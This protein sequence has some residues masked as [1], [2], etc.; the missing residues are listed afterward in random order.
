MVNME[1]LPT[2]VVPA[3]VVALAI[4][5]I[6]CGACAHSNPGPGRG[7]AAADGAKRIRVYVG[8]YT[9]TTSKGIYCL[10]L[11]PATG[12]L[13]PPEVAAETANPSFLAT[14]TGK[15]T[16]TLA[17]TAGNG[18]S[19]LS[20]FLYAVGEIADFEG[21]KSGSVSAFAMDRTSGKLTLLNQQPSGGVGPCHLIVDHAGKNL[22]VAN[23]SSG[24]VAVC[25]IG[26]DGRLA[27]PSDIAQHTGV[28]HRP[29]YQKSPHAHSVN[30]DAAGRFA[31]VADLG[32]DKVFVYRF[33]A[34]RG[35]LVPNDPAAVAVAPGTG[36][37]H[38]AF[39]PTGR[40]AYVI[41]ELGS[42]VT[43]FA[44]DSAR[45]VLTEVQTVST[46]PAGVPAVAEE[47]STA[48]VAVHPSGRFLY[49]SNRGH[50]S[51]AVFAIDEKTGKLTPISHQSTLGKTPRNF[52]IDPAG[53]WLLA[54][55]QDSD[56]IV[57]FRID[58]RTGGLTPTGAKVT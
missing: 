24:S 15:G 40:F 49:G 36:P 3:G 11:D 4:L 29:K 14:S 41:N 13:T 7:P 52:G 47:T 50:G 21:R 46:L 18:A 23:Y 27:P 32:L 28:G 16:G 26:A 37:R 20:R 9:K 45:G 35:K 51:I 1:C 38:F 17:K 56:S 6:F 10:W 34:A 58:A 5:P 2:W 31:F 8:T 43:A 22:L 53:N 39:H 33:D 54:A 44:Y 30:L 48:E 42:T 25:P 57:V 12:Q 55:N 19:P